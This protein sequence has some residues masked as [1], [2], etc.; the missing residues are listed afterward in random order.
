M[1]YQSFGKYS[2]LFPIALCNDL[3]MSPTQEQTR[4]ER[5][6]TSMKK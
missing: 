1:A 5:L 6:S 3:A 4:L 2:L